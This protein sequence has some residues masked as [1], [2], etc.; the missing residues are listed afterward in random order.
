MEKGD[1]VIKEVNELRK[2]DAPNAREGTAEEGRGRERH[3][4][5]IAPILQCQEWSGGAL[6]MVTTAAGG[7]LSQWALAG[8]RPALHAIPGLS[9]GTMQHLSAGRSLQI[10]R[11]PATSG[12]P[13]RGAMEYLF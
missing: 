12:F 4:Q 2:A 8:P 9:E 6:L 11:T 3:L 10:L 13:Q 7:Q 1:H 5:G